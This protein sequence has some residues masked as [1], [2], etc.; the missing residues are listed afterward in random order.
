MGK[1]VRT[2]SKCSLWGV[3]ILIFVSVGTQD[4]PFDR[5]LKSVEKQIELGNIKEKVIVQA[6]VTNFKSDKM[7]IVGFIPMEKFKKIIEESKMIICHGGVGTITDGLRNNKIVIACPRLAKYNEHVN[8][9]QL[10]I[11]NNFGNFGYII[12]LLDPENLAEALKKAKTFK[13]KM[14]KSNTKNM[15]QLLENFID[16]N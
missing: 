3:D 5:L 7:E 8:D 14:Y 15:I 11:I 9:H 2:L 4:I 10:Q 1:H 16:K 13:P 12:P 6:G